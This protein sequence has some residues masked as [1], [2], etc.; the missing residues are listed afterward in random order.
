MVKVL[1]V[2]E[3][4]CILNK[5]KRSFSCSVYFLCCISSENII[6]IQA[7]KTIDNLQLA[8]SLLSLQSNLPLHSSEAS[9]VRPSLHWNTP[10][11]DRTQI[12]VILHLV[13]WEDT[14]LKH[15]HYRGNTSPQWVA[16][17]QPQICD[18]LDKRHMWYH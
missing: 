17:W 5:K 10:M 6:T 2:V 18:L 12:T 13:K 9:M 16:E 4:Q 8:S 1:D 11:E 7:N 3:L 14:A 15:R